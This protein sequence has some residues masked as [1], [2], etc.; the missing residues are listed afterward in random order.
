MRLPSTLTIGL[1]S[2]L[3]LSSC[4]INRFAVNLAADAL[5]GGDNAVV[6]SDND[7]ELVGAAIP[8]TLKMYET[9]LSQAPDHRALA[10]STGSTFVMY[11]N[12]FVQ[13]P[14]EMLR[15][16]QYEER[17]RQLKR[18]QLLYQR[19]VLILNEALNRSYPGFSSAWE[20]GKLDAILPKMRRSDVPFMY[21]TAAAT[22][23][24]YSVDPFNLALGVRLGAAGALMARA[25][26]LDPDFQ[27]GTI[28]EFYISYFA[29]LPPGLGG[30]RNRAIQ[31]Y[32]LAIQKSKGESAG[33][34]LAYAQAICVPDQDFKKFKELLSK[35]LAIDVDAD[36]S[37]RL[38]NVMAQRK[39]HYL[40]DHQ[41]DLF[42][43]TDEAVEGDF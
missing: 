10:L 29:S 26:E 18:A 25:Y 36:P 24:S 9:L 20:A 30:D 8:F 28:D 1:L 13:G 42:I 41:D 15:E 11:A 12:A 39:A 40:L 22:L 43:V 5:S 19:G 35:V 31:H 7:P 32:D 16:D 4:S 17:E 23:A 2:L 6:M 34:Y 38:V 37:H 27:E 3:G 33:P 14:A 21:W